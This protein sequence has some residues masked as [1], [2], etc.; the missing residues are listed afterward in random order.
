[1]SNLEKEKILEV[2]DLSVGFVS[3][4]KK[5]NVIRNV[6]IDVYQGETLAIV[7]ESGSGKSVFTKTFTGMLDANGYISSG[8]IIFHGEDL[9]K[10]LK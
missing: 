3:H 10:K 5:V 6:S 4:G 2:R 1:M 8:S 7:G 9:A